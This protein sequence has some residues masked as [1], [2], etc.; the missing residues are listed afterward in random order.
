MKRKH[1]GFTMIELL[2]S[3]AILALAT[4]AL[5]RMQI[6]SISLAA[7]NN[8]TIRALAYGS[9]EMDEITAYKDIDAIDLDYTSEQRDPETEELSGF[10][11][12]GDKSSV[13]YSQIPATEFNLKIKYGNKEYVNLKTFKIK[14]M[15]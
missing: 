14:A 7:E 13:S 11:A 12:K 4:A 10:T 1:T 6:N 9:A 3:I 15:R 5:S 2:V 8:L